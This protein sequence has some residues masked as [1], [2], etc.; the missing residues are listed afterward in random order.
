M[1]KTEMVNRYRELVANG[2]IDNAD[3]YAYMIVTE[4]SN[5]SL[6]E[7]TELLDIVQDPTDRAQIRDTF[8]DNLDFPI[9]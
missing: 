6:A 5:L 2:D 1:T 7:I 4:D 8:R 9:F 3:E